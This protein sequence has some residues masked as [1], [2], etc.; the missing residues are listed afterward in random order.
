MVADFDPQ[1]VSGR[2][3]LTKDEN[4]SLTERSISKVVAGPVTPT[5]Y[6]SDTND[7]SA[8]RKK[9]E[10]RKAKEKAEI[11][12]FIMW[13]KFSK[14]V[15]Y[16]DVIFCGVYLIATAIF[17]L[18]LGGTT[19]VVQHQAQVLTQERAN[20]LSWF[21]SNSLSRNF[22]EGVVEAWGYIWFLW[23][24]SAVFFVITAVRLYVAKELIS[25]TE[26]SV[27]P[28]PREAGK[29]FEKANAWKFVAIVTVVL[30]VLLTFIC[31]P[32][33]VI[34]SLQGASIYI[35]WKY[36]EALRAASFETVKKERMWEEMKR[37]T[38][39]EYSRQ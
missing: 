24:L 20:P 12:S 29:A 23:L 25:A 30:D 9:F 17:F 10:E 3:E 31:R 37:K 16:I 15:G 26:T 6:S 18:F 35:V 36:I 7:S 13:Q 28:K 5:I 4:S 38:T 32:F 34:P 8:A 14:A 11:E 19:F 27:R 33:I 2:P 1:I 39:N 21:A 22:V